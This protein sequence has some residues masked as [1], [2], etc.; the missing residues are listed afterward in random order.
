MDDAPG[1]GGDWSQMPLP[2]SLWTEDAL[3]RECCIDFAPLALRC[4]DC[5]RYPTMF[6]RHG[7]AVL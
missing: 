1:A 7:V 5:V 3:Q 6:R 2:I 4:L